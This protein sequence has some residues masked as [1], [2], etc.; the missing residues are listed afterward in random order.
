M[1]TEDRNSGP[2]A[3]GGVFAA[4][5]WSVVLAAAEGGSP[6]AAAALEQLCR[7]YWYPLYAYLRRRGFRAEDAQDLT[8]EFFTRLVQRNLPGQAGRGCGT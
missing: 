2:G 7:T 3:H 8:Q 5:H 6:R 1:R 4:T